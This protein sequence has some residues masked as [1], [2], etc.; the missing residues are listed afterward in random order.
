MGSSISSNQLTGGLT[1]QPGSSDHAVAKRWVFFQAE[2]WVFFKTTSTQLRR[3]SL[4]VSHYTSS[5]QKQS[6]IGHHPGF[7]SAGSRVYFFVR[8]HPAAG[9]HLPVRQ[10]VRQFSVSLNT[11]RQLP[12]L[13]LLEHLAGALDLHARRAGY[14]RRRA[15]AFDEFG[16]AVGR[17]RG[18]HRRPA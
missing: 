4:A 18:Q 15:H 3:P 13:G 12:E 7:T 6:S 9:C 14:S 2:T 8:Q 16:C 10:Y 17:H 5:T 11:V 1:S